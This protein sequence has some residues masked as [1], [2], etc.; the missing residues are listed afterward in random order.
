GG[1]TVA[2]A[3]TCLLMVGIQHSIGSDAQQ[4]RLH[5]DDANRVQAGFVDPGHPLGDSPVKPVDT[6]TK[7][8]LDA[9]IGESTQEGPVQIASAQNEDDMKLKLQDGKSSDLFGVT[10]FQV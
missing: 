10:E 6:D 5:N 7:S 8:L 4:A 9:L 3:L 2:V 1:F